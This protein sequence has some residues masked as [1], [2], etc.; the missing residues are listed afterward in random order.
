MESPQASE[1]ITGSHNYDLT[2]SVNNFDRQ[3]QP[4]SWNQVINE[5]RRKEYPI[6]FDFLQTRDKEN[7]N[8]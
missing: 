8:R 3:E 6:H 2:T 5:N 7:E 4:F 1:A